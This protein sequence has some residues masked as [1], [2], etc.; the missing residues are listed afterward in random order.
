[1]TGGLFDEHSAQ[2]IPRRTGR[3]GG[4]QH[5]CVSRDAKGVDWCCTCGALV[6]R[7]ERA[8]KRRPKWLP[9]KKGGKADA[10]TQAQNQTAGPEGDGNDG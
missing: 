7:P 10:A 4:C 1:M 6:P 8:T 9:K 2:G 3:A 5:K